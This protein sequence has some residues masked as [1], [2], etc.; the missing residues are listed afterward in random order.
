MSSNLVWNS[1]VELLFPV[2]TERENP[3]A[4]L[5]SGTLYLRVAWEE[6]RHLEN[7]PAAN[8]EEPVICTTPLLM[9]FIV[10][11]SGNQDQR[12]VYGDSVMM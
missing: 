7:H 4:S 10:L 12:N 6:G 9:C 5:G 1:S 8:T 11:S 2:F 3:E